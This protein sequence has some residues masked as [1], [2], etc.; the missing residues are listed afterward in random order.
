M[1]SST[2]EFWLVGHKNLTSPFQG[3]P[4]AVLNQD[5]S[6]PHEFFRDLFVQRPDGQV[7]IPYIPNFFDTHIFKLDFQSLL[8]AEELD[9]ALGHTCAPWGAVGLSTEYRPLTEEILQQ[10]F[11]S[12]SPPSYF[13]ASSSVFE[14]GN[15][16]IHENR[17]IIGL[18]SVI[19]TV[20]VI[21]QERIRNKRIKKGMLACEPSEHAYRMARN[22]GIF[23]KS[24]SEKEVQNASAFYKSL[25]ENFVES[26][27]DSEKPALKTK[28]CYFD[29]LLREAKNTL[30]FELGVSHLTV[31]PQRSY[32]IDLDILVT[33]SGRVLIRN[34]S[35]DVGDTELL[36]HKQTA[37]L[38]KDKWDVASLSTTPIECINGIF[39][40]NCFFSMKSANGTDLEEELKK[41]DITLH[42]P[43]EVGFESF[44]EDTAAGLRCL[45]Q[46]LRLNQKECRKRTKSLSSE[47]GFDQNL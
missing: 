36:Y 39:I 23:L 47:Y 42:T 45:T 26:I 19:L 33:P 1:F 28:A 30:Q 11:E 10:D 37:E 16:F 13:K 20:M 7:V 6:L 43:S 46:C 15:V 4:I 38:M 40:E 25:R 9:A 22:R 18:H 27:E 5:Y 35:T 32:H 24:M 21:E 3:K 12:F 2:Q 34:P 14:G 29:S 31:I 41:E 44:Y 8:P 17:A